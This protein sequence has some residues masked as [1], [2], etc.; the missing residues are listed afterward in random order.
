MMNATDEIS[1]TMELFSHVIIFDFLNCFLMMPQIINNFNILCVRLSIF[2]IV[3]VYAARF[4]GAWR[5]RP[6]HM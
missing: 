2:V 1:Q 4:S 5:G 6:S 3:F